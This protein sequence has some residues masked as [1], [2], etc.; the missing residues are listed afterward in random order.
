MFSTGTI[1]PDGTSTATINRTNLLSDGWML[2]NM[3]MSDL[4]NLYQ[5]NNSQF[6]STCPI[7]TPFIDKN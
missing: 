4:T 1:L 2:E 7:E 6:I 5:Q 3:S